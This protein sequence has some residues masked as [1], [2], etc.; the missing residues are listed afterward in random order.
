MKGKTRWL[1]VSFM[2]LSGLILFLFRKENDQPVADLP[3]EEEIR[4]EFHGVGEDSPPPPPVEGEIWW[5]SP[6]YKAQE[7]IF[8]YPR[9]YSAL[10]GEFDEPGSYER[11][12]AEEKRKDEARKQE[13]M[14]RPGLKPLI[15][16][17]LERESRSSYPDGL[18]GIAEAILW[19][20]DITAE[21]IK[22]IEERI[23]ELVKVTPSESSLSDNNY[24]I[25]MVRTLAKSSDPEA[26]I[27]VGKVIE[28]EVESRWKPNMLT[29]YNAV[30]ALTMIGSERSLPAIEK[31][32]KAI[33]AQQTE[34]NPLEWRLG[35]IKKARESILARKK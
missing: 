35:R 13:I 28:R 12:L 4:V 25:Y 18:K 5:E 33:L 19:R 27:L 8:T 32:D 21:D 3:K 9:D 29:L 24:I 11:Y 16:Q 10:T 14:T 6:L 7:L 1:V 20:S 26:E 22:P 15:F 31:A 2:L 34:N 30:D 23:K 17:L